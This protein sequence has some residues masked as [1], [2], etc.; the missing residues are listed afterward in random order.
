MINSLILMNQLTFILVLC[1]F[2]CTSTFFW[3]KWRKIGLLFLVL[4]IATLFIFSVGIGKSL[5]LGSMRL[6]PYSL[7]INLE[8][9]S[10]FNSRGEIILDKLKSWNKILR[11]KK[12]IYTTKDGSQILL[13]PLGDQK[14]IKLFKRF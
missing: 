5:I 4:I 2:I 12:S 1:F 10:E 13:D 6:D 14:S 3:I 7:V 11:G 9:N 8:S